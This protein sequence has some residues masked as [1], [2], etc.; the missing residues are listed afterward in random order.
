VSIG[1]H[2]AHTVMLMHHLGIERA[3]VVGHSS[4]ANIALQLALDT[5]DAVT[6]LTLLEPARPDTPTTAALRGPG[7]GQALELFHAG[8]RARAVDT[9]LQTVAG[10]EYRAALEQAAPH[11]SAQAEASADTFFGIKLPSLVQWS[12]TPEEA[13]RVQQP[14]LAVVGSDSGA[15]F[16]ARH[17]LLLSW[18]PNVDAF[19]LPNAN[20]LLYLQNAAPLAER[21]AEF[22]DHI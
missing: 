21:M 4:S 6:S 9:F 5:P 12:F 16:Q 8:H 15:V 13:A 17:K 10:R 7:V 14:T 3:H 22:F 20:H 1:D 2:A 11:A 18:L 19:V